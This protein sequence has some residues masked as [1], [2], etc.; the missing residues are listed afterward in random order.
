MNFFY[1]TFIAIAGKMDQGRDLSDLM[2]NGGVT[3]W[4]FDLVVGDMF[5]MQ[6]LRGILS[7]HNFRLVMAL[8]TFSLWY[9]A[10]PLNYTEVTFFTG[11]P[12][13]NILTMIEIPSLDLNVPFGLDVARGTTPY[14]TWNTF[15]IATCASLE[16]VTNEAIGLVNCEVGSLDDLGMAG[17]TSEFHPS[18]QLA[19]MFSMGKG[20]ILI[21]HISLEILNL[22]ASLLEAT[23]IV[24]LRM[25]LARSFSGDKVG[26]RHLTIHPLP[27]QMVE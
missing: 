2:L 6:D 18:P 15:L 14:G 11:H 23:R 4:T 10:I 24:D 20:H 7:A 27:S 5:F 8:D 13:C 25:R 19:Q 16:V 17:G 22:M 9:M 26:Q 12:S 1:V 3:I 21:N